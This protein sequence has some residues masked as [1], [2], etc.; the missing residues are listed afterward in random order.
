MG[1]AVP[2]QAAP[3][4]FIPSDLGLLGWNY[5]PNLA[6]SGTSLVSGTPL[7]VRVNV[8]APQ[9]VTGVAVIVFGA[10]TGLTAAQ[11]LGGAL[12]PAGTVIGVTADQSGV[13]TAQGLYLM[14][15]AGGP[16]LV[17]PPFAMVAA[18]ANFTG[19]AP[20]LG[21]LGASA[22]A[23]IANAGTTSATSRYSNNATGQT[24]ILPVNLAASGQVN[25]PAWAGLY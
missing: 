23:G 6:V 22:T 15:F 17:T 10:G 9:L 18:L 11:C 13:W 20:Q 25:A 7:L 5:D 8:R 12:T 3:A 2:P 14:P 16:Q 1:N 4:G 19:T 21:R 24:T